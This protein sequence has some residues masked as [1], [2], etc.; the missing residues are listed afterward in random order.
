[1]AI[2]SGRLIFSDLMKCHTAPRKSRGWMCSE[3]V[4]FARGQ[5]LTPGAGVG[6][7]GRSRGWEHAPRFPCPGAP[8]PTCLIAQGLCCRRKII[9]ARF[10]A[11]FAHLQHPQSI[12]APSQHLLATRSTWLTLSF[13]TKRPRVSPQLLLPAPFLQGPNEPKSHEQ[14]AH[15]AAFFQQAALTRE[16]EI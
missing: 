1:M 10:A 3:L 2:T 5:A 12:L 16:V 9:F 11:W 7:R 6:Q 8:R 14:L 4:P 15:E 13:G